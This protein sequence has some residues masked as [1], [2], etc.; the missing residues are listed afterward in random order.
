VSPGGSTHLSQ[1]EAAGIPSHPPM[2]SH[3]GGL[4]H[5]P[6]W[7]PPFCAPPGRATG[8]RIEATAGTCDIGFLKGLRP[9]RVRT[10]LHNL[11]AARGS[12]LRNSAPIS[13]LF[14]CSGARQSA[15][16]LAGALRADGDSRIPDRKP[17]RPE[18][19]GERPLMTRRP[20]RRRR[21]GRPWIRSGPMLPLDDRAARR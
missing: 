15:A 3:R 10:C 5:L 18:G 13:R 20:P 16:T 6:G 8:P 12:H 1:F 9:T 19:K 4:S 21:P 14:R 11:P 17:H 2:A 7:R